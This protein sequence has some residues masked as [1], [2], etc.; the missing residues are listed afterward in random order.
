[1]TLG[2]SPAAA[3]RA[4]EG[5]EEAKQHVR[6]PT[7]RPMGGRRS[8][9]KILPP[10]TAASLA[11]FDGR[12]GPSTPDGVEVTGRSAR[13]SGDARG[14]DARGDDHRA[15]ASAHDQPSL[16]R[17]LDASA[18]PAASPAAPR[19]TSPLGA[20]DA[21][22]RAEE[23]LADDG[24]PVG[25]R[26]VITASCDAQENLS[27]VPTASAEDAEPP[28]SVLR[29]EFPTFETLEAAAASFAHAPFGIPVPIPSSSPHG[30]ESVS[31]SVSGIGVPSL[32]RNSSESLRATTT[33]SV[34]DASTRDFKSPEDVAREVA[35]LLKAATALVRGGAGGRF[36]DGQA[37]VDQALRL[38]PENVEAVCAAGAIHF[39]AGK[40]EE[41]YARFSFALEL[42]PNHVPALQALGLLYQTRGMLPEA[43][44]AYAAAIASHEEQSS[45]LAR[46]RDGASGGTRLDENE[47]E[48]AGSVAAT[49]ARLAATL[50]D[51]G[52]QVKLEGDVH[53]AMSQYR[54]AISVDPSYAPALYNLGVALHELG[55]S[56]A[57]EARYAEAAALDPKHADAL[58]NLG[59][60]RKL[61]G[62]VA[63]SVAAYEACLAVNP[64]HVH[65]TSNMAIALNDMAN[66]A[67]LAGDVPAAI[68]IYERA[69]T[70]DSNSADSMYNLGVAQAEVGELDRAVIAYETTLKL[71]PGCAEAWNNLG[72]LLRE[73]GNVPRAVECYKNAISLKPHFAQ[74]CNN[75]GV[76]CTVQGKAQEALQALQSAV[77]ADPEYAVAHNN[78]GVLL[79][80]TGDVHEALRSY[81][82]CMR[83][84]PDDRNASQNYLLA[85]NYVFP[86]Q[87]ARVCDAHV[88]WGRRMTEL[89]GEPM[90]PRAFDEARDAGAGETI[91]SYAQT[92]RDIP[93]IVRRSASVSSLGTSS[94]S[95][96]DDL[97]TLEGSSFSG[98]ETGA[99]PRPRSRRLVVGYVSPDMYTHSVSYFAAAPLRH[100]NPKRVRL[101]VYSATP[102]ED[103]RTGSLRASVAASGGEWRDVAA[104]SERALAE[105]I[106][107]DGVD[108][109]V[110]LTGHTANNRLATLALR[111]APVQVTWM[112][113]PNSTGM[114]GAVGYRVTDKH[115]DPEDTKQ[116]FA[117]TSVRLP[118]CFLC[119]T[120]HPEAPPVSNAPCL[121]NGFVTFG[122]FNALAKVTPAVRALWGKLLRLVPNSRLVVK[123]KP[124]ACASVQ[125]RFLS[126]MAAEGVASWRVDVRALVDRTSEHLGAYGEIDV[127]LDTFPYAGTT[128][129]CE[130]LWSG[131][132]V[133]TLKGEA[134]AH[135][136]GVSLLRTVGIERECVAENE[137][138][139][140]AKCAALAADHAALGLMRERMREKM[141]APG[142]LCDGEAF[143][144]KLEEAYVAMWRRH[145]EE[146]RVVAGR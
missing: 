32:A 109:L 57:A 131:V 83:L 99:A 122:C 22:R 143:T 64:N 105:L 27:A 93:D 141:R 89:V 10:T 102:V 71:R 77:A 79:R 103:A 6:A 96:R 59:V 124:F 104:L 26:F 61:R 37:L 11:S 29:P 24:T 66:A 101:I 39:S 91:C 112:G 115:V 17:R 127:A 20:A 81:Q 132:P 15:A 54:E 108:V 53:K 25:L 107:H 136:V 84:S 118:G 68:R 129:T 46:S 9:H 98:A 95:S 40:L 146:S 94:A 8:Q 67:K 56:A 82:E 140:V 36:A 18:S 49:R 13:G 135:N 30:S 90:P 100:H 5:S 125:R 80:D 76:L 34:A 114:A 14:A 85:L 137:E 117:E 52:T 3:A 42:R 21:R 43:A 78:V 19:V 44:R 128:T 74:A 72:V 119:Y 48:T 47:N 145:C 106:R 133:V 28:R 88:A 45:A 23:T 31:V 60:M 123:A 69:L 121:A 110:E 50:S 2:V 111:P 120:P 86:G 139:Y 16:A 65:G 92:S 75:L 55:Q 63:G 116:T 97:V 144:Q 138:A 87:D 62:D 41:A 70:F 73:R 7:V 58:C 12:D 33:G 134:H 4:T 38:A 1:M 142:G 113:Y 35:R 51:I 130:A 126:A